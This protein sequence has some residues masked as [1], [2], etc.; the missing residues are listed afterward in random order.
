MLTVRIVNVPPFG[1][2]SDMAAVEDGEALS[3]K[4]PDTFAVPLTAGTVSALGIPA[5]GESVGLGV[6]VGAAVAVSSGWDVSVGAA[7]AVSSG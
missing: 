2:L 7:L 4:L 6:S 1:I 3:D 5:V